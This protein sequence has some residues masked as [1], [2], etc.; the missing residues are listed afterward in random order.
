MAPSEKFAIL[1]EA[2]FLAWQTPQ[3][4]DRLGFVA[5][6]QADF[7]LM[8]GL[9]L[10]GTL[11]AAHTGSGEPGPAL[12]AW[13]SATWYFLPHMELRLDNIFRRNSSAGSVASFEYSLLVQLHLFL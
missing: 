2:D 11:E 10:V 4:L 3:Q 1:A 8:Q 5:F 13:A 9:H 7:D 6:A 12:G